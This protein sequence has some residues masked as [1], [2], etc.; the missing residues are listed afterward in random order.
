[1]C[2]ADHL[3]ILC[4]NGNQDSVIR[5]LDKYTIT[6][7]FKITD[8]SSITTA[9]SLFGSQVKNRL[10]ERFELAEIKEL[11]PFNYLQSERDILASGA[12]LDGN[13]YNV[14]VAKEHEE[15]LQNKL[16]A[17]Q[18]TEISPYIYEV[19][20]IESGIP[21]F[22]KELNDIH[23]PLE[24]G[25]TPAVSFT[26]GCYIGQEVI[27]RL[28]SYNKVQRKLCRVEAEINE[29][30]TVPAQLTDGEKEIGTLTSAAI[31]PATK[32]MI[33]LCYLPIAW[34]SDKKPI[35]KI[36]DKSYPLTVV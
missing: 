17:N 28:H 5:H 32:K 18:I 25:L 34:Q 22:G 26:K 23:N 35:L 13:G 16:I 12:W 19:L 14:F 6:E 20:R 15:A 3:L 29:N 1:Y 2:F 11:T 9:Y 8:I 21:A 30:V 36:E 33:G 4:A 24:A 10:I 31:N 27:A 7:D